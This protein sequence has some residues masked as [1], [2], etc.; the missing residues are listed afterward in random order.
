MQEKEKKTITQ[1][2][3][4]LAV[5]RSA[6]YR[7]ITKE[8]LNSKLKEHSE[9]IRGITY[10]ST[11][12][13]EIITASPEY[14]K[15]KK[16]SAQ[17]KV[18]TDIPED[19]DDDVNYEVVQLLK[20]SVE[21]LQEQL[22]IKDTQLR[23]QLEAKDEQIARLT[24]ALYNAQEIQRQTTVALQAAEALHNSTMK[25]LTDAGQKKKH[26][27]QRKTKESDKIADND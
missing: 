24:E 27:W 25:Q 26:W 8:P 21:L 20:E 19:D 18:S 11:E 23:E 22:S 5:D 10:Y 14:E 4:A 6:L 1:I 3:K 13:L 15:M 17:K 7:R 12:A 16:I 9:T 2:A